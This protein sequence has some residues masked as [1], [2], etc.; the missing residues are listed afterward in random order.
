MGC[1]C[2]TAHAGALYIVGG[3]A[4]EAGTGPWKDYIQ[5]QSRAILILPQR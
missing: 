4:A 5:Y 3:I 1:N 2:R